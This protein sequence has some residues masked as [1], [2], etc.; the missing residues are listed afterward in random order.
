[1]KEKI[2]MI[3]IIFFVWFLMNFA[4]KSIITS[5]IWKYLLPGNSLDAFELDIS[6]QNQ[7]QNR[8]L[9]AKS[10]EKA[11]N[12]KRVCF[13]WNSLQKQIQ[14]CIMDPELLNKAIIPSDKTFHDIN[15]TVL[16]TLKLKSHLNNC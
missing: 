16:H 5:Y 14:L 1:M 6:D 3:K 11:F 13:M 9:L 10:I 2:P 4:C 8:M 15:G 7:P 12:T